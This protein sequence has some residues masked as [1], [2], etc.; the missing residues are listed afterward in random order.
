MKAISLWQPWASAIALGVKQIETRAWRTQLVGE[1]FAICAAQKRT[2]QQE[3]F[4]NDVLND[5]FELRCAFGDAMDLD[6][7]TL[8]FGKVL[9]VATLQ[10]VGEV[11]WFKISEIERALGDF[12]AGRFGWKFTNVVHLKTPVPVIGR[13]GLFNLPAEVEAK[14]REQL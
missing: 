10:A 13:Q 2:L 11:E 9:A 14:V 1:Q 4:F 7:Q 3:E 12:S 8:P 6:F 5:H